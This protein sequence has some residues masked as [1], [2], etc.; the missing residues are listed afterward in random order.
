[1]KNPSSKILKS[2][3]KLHIDACQVQGL[4]DWKVS[5]DQELVQISVIGWS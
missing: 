4:R 3:D 5:V 2:T 1:M